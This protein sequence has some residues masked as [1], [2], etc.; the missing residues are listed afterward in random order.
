[1]NVADHVPVSVFGDCSPNDNRTVPSPERGS[2]IEPDQVPAGDAGDDVVVGEVGA[3]SLLQPAALD[4]STTI[5][6]SRQAPAR[7]NFPNIV[8]VAESRRVVSGLT[9]K[10]PFRDI[11]IDL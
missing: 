1:V 9:C 5:K 2:T 3:V 8:P 6:A 4:I 11:R 7:R 10:G